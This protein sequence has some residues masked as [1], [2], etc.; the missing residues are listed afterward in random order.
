MVHEKTCLDC[1]KRLSGRGHPVRCR[2]CAARHRYIIEHGKPP[3]IFVGHCAVC[4]LEFKDYA[5][6]KR[7][8]A[9]HRF[10]SEKCRASWV[11]VHN[12]ISRGGDG[13][14][15]SKRQKDRLYYRANA[16]RI[17]RA[18]REYYTRHRGDVLSK[19]SA[20]DREIKRQVVAAY[21]GAC[22]CCGE[23]HIELLTIDHIHG[24]GNLHRRIVG[25][26]RRI[27]ADLLRLG[28]PKDNYRLLCFNCNI[29]R[30]FYGYCPHQPDDR[31]CF[32]KRPKANAGRPRSVA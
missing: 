32:D 21:G 9:K 16:E 3:D 20:K 29:S 26:G 18:M 23:Q 30:G 15:R 24:D 1:R 13:R 22:D 11:G 14:R 5:S 19:R 7:K 10:C 2:S 17:R 4:G 25:K 31:Q 12:S 8:P 28:C 6:N 27:Y